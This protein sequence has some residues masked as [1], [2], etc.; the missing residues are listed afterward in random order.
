MPKKVDQADIDARYDRVMH[1]Q[2]E[3]HAAN[4]DRWHNQELT[5]LVDEQIDFDTFACRHFG[6]ASE[7]DNITR[8]SG[9]VLS[10]GDW[11]TVPHHRQRRL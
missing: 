11:A 2:A 10:V 3:I 1:A 6:Q 9:A 8:V 7:V 4:L 5:V